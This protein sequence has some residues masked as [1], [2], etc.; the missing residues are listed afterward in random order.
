[1]ENLGDKVID[2]FHVVITTLFAIA[3]AYTFLY[4]V[5]GIFKTRRFAKTQ[6]QFR[7]AFVIPARNEAAVIAHLIESIQQQDYPADL[8]SIFVVADNS[9]DDTALVARQA[10]AAVYE[11]FDKVHQTKGYALQFLFKQIDRDYG[12]DSFDGYFIFDADNLLKTDYVSRMNE[13]FASGEKVITA[14][15]N[16]KNLDTNALSAMNS[17]H[18]LRT[19]RFSHRPRSYLRLSTTIQGTGFL[20][21][22]D[23]VKDGWK[24]VDLTE[25]RSLSVDA[26]LSGYKVTYCD[27]AEFYDEQ[28]T[29]FR[30][31]IRQRKRWAK[32]H[33][34]IMGRV[35]KPLFRNIFKKKSFASYDMMIVNIPLVLIL[36]L[37]S[38]F[39][40][41]LQLFSSW[42]DTAIILSLF[43]NLAINSMVTWLLLSLQAL[44]IFLVDRRR[45]IRLSWIKKA[46]II[47][48][49]PLFDILEIPTKIMALFS[50]DK[51]KPIP[52]THRYRLKDIKKS[53][54]GD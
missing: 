43:R 46:W 9:D 10:G 48:T 45:L 49:W 5:I 42:G 24:W 20:V 18:F 34:Q 27:S 1:M 2:I 39:V 22:N 33:L 35:T 44:Y 31:V 51:Y 26:L 29:T 50:S 11:R 36:F 32:G 12:I 47:L 8:L 14:F 53:T 7:Y 30:M 13:A 41:I 17:M 38:S 52:H 3:N 4:I 40:F 16:S 54:S 37:W 25:D 19:N 15:R 6:K 21:A 23:I 28:P